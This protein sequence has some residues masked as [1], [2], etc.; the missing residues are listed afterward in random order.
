MTTVL[1]FA[2]PSTP[3]YLFSAN[4][5]IHHSSN[6]QKDEKNTFD[7][8]FGSWK[9]SF[10]LFAHR[11]MMTHKHTHT[12]KQSCRR[13]GNYQ[14]FHFLRKAIFVYSEIA[15]MCE[16]I[17]VASFI[18]ENIEFSVHLSRMATPFTNMRITQTL[19]SFDKFFRPVLSDAKAK[20]FSIKYEIVVFILQFAV[21]ALW[22]YV[23]WAHITLRLASAKL[24]FNHSR[25][26]TKC[27]DEK[28][29]TFYQHAKANI[30]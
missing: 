26:H 24:P 21:L 20:A 7:D 4:T 14:K 13:N 6:R 9:F 2:N 23:H 27:V 19:I 5:H 16:R 17:G 15:Y 10:R 12:T 18:N 28:T 30:Y 8:T 11:T 3:F 29:A 1:W 22:K 25:E